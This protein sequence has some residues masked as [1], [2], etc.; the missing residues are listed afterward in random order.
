MA[1]RYLEF[2]RRRVL[3]LNISFLQFFEVAHQWRFGRVGALNDD[4]CQFLQHAVI[5]RYVE[6]YLDHLKEKDDEENFD[7]LHAGVALRPPGNRVGA[8]A[9]SSVGVPHDPERGA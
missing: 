7:R 3:D 4:Y 9:P 6:A 5:P 8:T 2:L 1:Q